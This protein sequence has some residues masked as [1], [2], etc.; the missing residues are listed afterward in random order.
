MSGAGIIAA[1]PLFVGL[2]RPATFFGVSYVYCIFNILINMILFINA[3]SL[4]FLLVLLPIFHGIGYILCIKE[5][6]FLELYLIKVK[7]CNICKNK[8]YHGAN[9]YD[10][11]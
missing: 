3:E 11:Y 6:L 8:L 5:P 2:T 4:I 1:D 10:C 9:S 7:K